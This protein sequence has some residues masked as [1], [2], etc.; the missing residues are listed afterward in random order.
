MGIA[1]TKDRE[2]AFCRKQHLTMDNGRFLQTA[3]KR[4]VPVVLLMKRSVA[5]KGARTGGE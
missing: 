4:V 5:W 1:A 3:A 2:I